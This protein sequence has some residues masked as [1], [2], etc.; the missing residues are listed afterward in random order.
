MQKHTAIIHNNLTVHECCIHT[1]IHTLWTHGAVH[2][3]YERM[4]IHTY[5]QSYTHVSDIEV[6][7]VSNLLHVLTSGQM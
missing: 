7:S 2:T 6:V 3:V 4:Y 5:I 1:Y